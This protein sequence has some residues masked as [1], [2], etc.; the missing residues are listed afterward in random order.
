MSRRGYNTSL[1][2][3][4]AAPSSSGQ[5]LKLALCSSMT[6]SWSFSAFTGVLQNSAGL[7]SYNGISAGITVASTNGALSQSSSTNTQVNWSP[8]SVA[9]GGPMQSMNSITF[10]VDVNTPTLGDVL[11]WQPCV[12]GSVKQ[13]WIA[14]TKLPCPN[15]CPPDRTPLLPASVHFLLRWYIFVSLWCEC[16]LFLSFWHICRS[17][18]KR[19]QPDLEWLRPEWFNPSLCMQPGEPW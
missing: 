7:Y 5:L 13:F 3:Q 15:Q 1:C 14:C 8:T 16:M 2:A 9:G 18:C 12:R 19:M 10:C 11:V 4:P 6:T 17:G